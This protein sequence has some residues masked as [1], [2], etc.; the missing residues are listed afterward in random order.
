M[1]T[2]V[3]EELQQIDLDSEMT[4]EGRFYI[5]PSGQRYPSITTVLSAMQSAE[6]KQVLANWKARV[7]EAEANKVSRQ[8]TS[9]G[10]GMHTICENYTMNMAMPYRGQMPT[11]IEMFK[12]VRPVLDER[13]GTIYANEIALFSDT[14]RTAGRSDMVAQFDGI[15]SIVDFKTSRT[16]KKEQWITDYFL[17][18]TAY[19]IMLEEMYQTI[20]VPQIAIIIAVEEGG[21]QV[22]VKRTAEYRE[23][24]Y[25]IF[26]Q[27]HTNRNV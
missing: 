26:S 16:E 19:A 15:R 14:L 7:G 6:K 11:A 5:T 9:R 3:R 10:T 12:K 22:F 4:N 13:V 18:S 2:F 23:Q 24:V 21:S 1:K 25:Q 8:A 20:K 27:Y 17:Q